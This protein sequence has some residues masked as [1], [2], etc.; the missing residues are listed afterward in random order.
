MVLK[1]GATHREAADH[2]VLFSM[3]DEGRNADAKGMDQR[4]RHPVD[5]E[6]LALSGSF[7]KNPDENPSKPTSPPP[8]ARLQRTGTPAQSPGA[9]PGHGA[10]RG[11]PRGR[12][13]RAGAS[14]SGAP[15]PD[16]ASG[17]GSRDVRPGWVGPS[18]RFPLA[19]PPSP[20]P[21]ARPPP[22]P[23]RERRPPA[24]Q[25]VG[26]RG[27]GRAGSEPGRPGLAGAGLWPREGPGRQN[28]RPRRGP[29]GRAGRCRWDDPCA[30]TRAW[31]PLSLPKMAM[32]LGGADGACRTPGSW[33]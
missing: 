2:T 25:G 26:E 20:L 1:K 33:V 19:F 24:P 32:R 16:G 11:P 17:R 23:G 29:S 10:Q 31:L 6:R 22:C 15:G 21:C 13:Q 18:E 8:Q 9:A 7:L 12:G 4:S 3:E 30:E 27:R 5:K 14:P 28:H